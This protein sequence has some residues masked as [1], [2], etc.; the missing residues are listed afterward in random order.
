[1]LSILLTNRAPRIWTQRGKRGDCGVSANENSC[2][3]HVTWSPNIFLRSN[4]IFNLWSSL[5]PYHRFKRYWNYHSCQRPEVRIAMGYTG[6]CDCN[7][8]QA[9]TPSTL[10]QTYF[11]TLKLCISHIG[12]W[13][14]I[15]HIKTALLYTLLYSV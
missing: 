11:W 10:Q 15:A 13:R 1:M 3:H 8:S 9:T 4:S 14:P 6:R 5:Y 12:P 2:A 7:Q